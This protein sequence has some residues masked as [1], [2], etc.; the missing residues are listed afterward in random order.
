LKDTLDV[1]ISSNR[2]RKVTLEMAERSTDSPSLSWGAASDK[3]TMNCPALAV[4]WSGISRGG[5]MGSRGRVP[6]N[7]AII[8]YR[9]VD[10]IQASYF[11]I[12]CITII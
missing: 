3:S 10:I 9:F 7:A 12:L 11:R 4:L 8:V 2:K 5:P 1:F 6:L